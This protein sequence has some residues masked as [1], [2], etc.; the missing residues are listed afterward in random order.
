MKTVYLI[1]D[2]SHCKEGDSF[3]ADQ[4]NYLM[5]F[6]QKEDAITFY[7]NQNQPHIEI[8]EWGIGENGFPETFLGLC[9]D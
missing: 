2:Y 4:I 1:A 3:K 9:T 8:E 7:K 5:T 6:D